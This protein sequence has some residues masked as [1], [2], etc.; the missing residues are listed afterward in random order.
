MVQL[1]GLVVNM[2]LLLRQGAM[3]EDHMPP[4]TPI[5][6]K[7]RPLSASIADAYAK[8]LAFAVLVPNV[9]IVLLTKAYGALTQRWLRCPA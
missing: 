4:G 9:L 3:L 8:L 6:S 7:Q 2:T 5:F 1:E